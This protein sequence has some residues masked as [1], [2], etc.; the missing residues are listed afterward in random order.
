MSILA[1]G[2]YPI[3]III[4]ANYQHEILSR[5]LAE[6]R[7][8][9]YSLQQ[10]S[11]YINAHRSESPHS[12][13]AINIGRDCARLYRS[14]AT[15]Y[16]LFEQ[17]DSLVGFDSPQDLPTNVQAIIAQPEIS[18]AVDSLFT[19]D[20]RDKFLV[21]KHYGNSTSTHFLNAGDYSPARNF[22]ST[23]KLIRQFL[24]H[25]YHIPTDTTL[26]AADILGGSTEFFG[27]AHRFQLE[28]ADADISLIAANSFRDTISAEMDYCAL[29]KTFPFDNQLVKFRVKGADLLKILHYMVRGIYCRMTDKDGDLLRI[30]VD[31]A[32][33]RAPH[34]IDC[35]GGIFWSIDVRRKDF[36]IR[37]DSLL[38]G[39]QFS[40]EQIYTIATSAFR[41]ERII[42]ETGIAAEVEQVHQD[43]FSAYLAYLDSATIQR[44]TAVGRLTL[45]PE[46]W[47]QNALHREIK[48]ITNKK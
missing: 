16:A 1:D 35:A 32:T 9:G 24:N 28:R 26:S 33:L 23:Y 17:I 39:R 18:N 25:K 8:K 37:V 30:S 36:S 13:F 4:T 48:I 21:I 34:N 10:V 7:T 40:E 45:H 14:A 38:N 44:A 47:T 42:K 12:T 41:A 19:K 29:N 46:R 20:C 6:N 22:D 2:V 3:R 27:C 15:H 43:W 11:T 5:N 31:G